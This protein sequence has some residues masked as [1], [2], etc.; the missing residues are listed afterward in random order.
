M[1]RLLIII[2][3]LLLFSN[4]TIAREVFDL[5][6]NWKFHFGDIENAESA[7]FNDSVWRT[8]NVPHDFQIAHPSYPTQTENNLAGLVKSGIGWYR[9]QLN[10][11][12]EWKGKR[13]LLDFESIMYVGDVYLNGQHIGGTDYGYLGFEID[14]TDLV[15][16][17]KPNII[18]VKANLQQPENS[19]WHTGGGL[20]RN[21]RLIVT[22]RNTYFARHPL[23]I[24]TPNVSSTQA[25]VVINAQ[26][27]RPQSKEP[28]YVQTIVRNPEGKAISKNTVTI[29]Q[30]AHTYEYRIDSI[31]INN[32]ELWDLD[33]P[34]LYTVESAI[35]TKDSIIDIATSTFGIRSIEYSPEFG[36]KL[37]GKKVVLKG[38]AN[39]HTLGALGAADYERANEKRIQTLKQFGINNIR[40]SHNPYSETFLNL[41]DQY[42]ILVVDELYDKW[43]TQYTGGRRD[44]NSLWQSDI[45]EF[46]KR[47]RNHPCVIM[48][49]LGNEN[50]LNPNLSFGDWGVTPYKLMRTLVQRYDTTR[51]TTATIH[52]H[53]RSL[54]TDSLPADLAYV[55]DI[56]A[57]NYRYTYTNN[58]K[59]IFPW[60]NF[61]L[62]EANV[63][64][65]GQSFIEFDK[66]KNIGIAYWGLIDYL[67]ESSNWPPY[68]W[69]NGTF[70]IDLQPKPSAFLLKSFFMPEEPVAHICI[71]NIPNNNKWSGENISTTNVYDHWNYRKG[72]SLNLWVISNADEMELILNGKSLGTKQNDRSMSHRANHTAWKKVPFEQGTLVAIARTNG[73][74]VAYHKIET[75]L[76]ATHLFAQH[77]NDNWKADGYDLQYITISALDSLNRLNQTCNNQILFNIEGP[78]EIVAVTNGNIKSNEPYIDFTRKLWNGEATVILRSKRQSGIVTLTATSRGLAPVKIVFETTNP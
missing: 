56:Q 25:T 19:R 35:I 29:K 61:Y 26:I 9:R 1:K 77:D 14:I 49:S 41:C 52:P 46:I 51:P 5:N 17:D 39:H 32:P 44:W 43:T 59:R 63:A 10:M 38:V 11:R 76:P 55:T 47:D 57:Y 33:T 71:S 18:A 45:P 42:G 24:I 53:G 74:V 54:T 62:S 23:Q 6:F 16:W 7:E 8:I 67:R 3:T 69:E 73:K 58:D 12:D 68:K 28:I 36:F 2:A 75:A 65:M 60:M 37:N 22:N 30:F 21:V 48:W 64:M 15:N 13:L 70:Y 78:A 4:I 31:T 40:T 66:E 34:N 20:T 72:D 27:T 50:Q